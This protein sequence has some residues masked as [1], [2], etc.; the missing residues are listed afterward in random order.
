MGLFRSQKLERNMATNTN[1]EWYPKKSIP[2]ISRFVEGT[3]WFECIRSYYSTSMALTGTDASILRP[4]Q[5]PSYLP[6]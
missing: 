1:L 5:I 6:K 4:A 3:K 2:D